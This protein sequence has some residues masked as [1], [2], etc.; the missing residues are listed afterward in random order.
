MLSALAGKLWMT[1]LTL[2]EVWVLSNF[3][4]RDHIYPTVIKAKLQESLASGATVSLFGR[5]KVE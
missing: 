2:L 5:H 1:A 3:E 4:E